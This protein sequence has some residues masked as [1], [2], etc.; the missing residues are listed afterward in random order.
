MR[1]WAV[2]KA[3]L[4]CAVDAS[5]LIFLYQLRQREE[6]VGTEAVNEVLAN[7]AAR[8]IRL[9]LIEASKASGSVDMS[10]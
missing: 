10:K 8:L 2:A 9:L 6:N 7:V 1:P 3:R 4:F 5:A